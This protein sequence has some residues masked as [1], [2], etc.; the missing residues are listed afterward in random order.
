MTRLAARRLLLLAFRGVVLAVYGVAPILVFL[1]ARDAIAQ[2][3]AHSTPWEMQ[4]APRGQA[5]S[6]GGWKATASTF[7]PHP[8]AAHDAL[9][10]RMHLP[11]T[12]P[13]RPALLLRSE[14]RFRAQCGDEALTSIRAIEPDE[15]YFHGW[16][17][18]M[19]GVP[20]RC[21][22]GAVTFEVLD[23]DAV[24]GIAVKL[25]DASAME[26]TLV[27]R[28]VPHVAIAAIVVLL[29]LLVLGVGLIRKGGREFLGFGAFLISGGV[30]VFVRSRFPG[31]FFGSKPWA[32]DSVELLTLYAIP[33][34]YIVFHRATFGSGLRNSLRV[35][36]WVSGLYF[37]VAA[38]IALTG[39]IPLDRTLS[40][41]QCLLTLVLVAVLAD[42]IRL[43][44]KGNADARL[45]MG[46]L[47]AACLVFLVQ[48]LADLEALPESMVDVVRGLP[49]VPMGFFV[50]IVFLGAIV[51]RRTVDVYD[52]LQVYARDLERQN[53]ALAES[54]VALETQ[55]HELDKKNTELSRINTLKDEFLANTSH[56]LRTPLNG[57]IGL[58][59]S[60]FETTRSRL[61]ASERAHLR[62]I[63]MSGKR[64][65]TLINDILDFSKLRHKSIEL[66]RRA[67]D[68]H[69]AVDAIVELSRPL[70]GA[71]SVTLSNDVPQSIAKVA[72]DENRLQQ[73]L[74]NLVANAIKF[75]HA[76]SVRIAATLQGDSVRVTVRDTGIGIDASKL[77]RIFESFEQADG[78]TEREYGGT[79]LGLAITKKLVELHGGRLDVTSEVGIG[80]TFS[81]T[82]PRATDE[83]ASVPAPAFR[84]EPEDDDA[85]APLST[86]VS[87][88]P[89]PR[90]RYRV[91]AA[92]DDPVNLAVLGAQLK[93]EGFDIVQAADGFEALARL[94]GPTRF[95]AL[96]LD[97]M[98]PRMSGYEV[99]RRVRRI[100]ATKELPVLLLTAKNQPDDIVEGFDAGANDYLTKPFSRKELLARVQTHI[101]M[102]QK[103]TAFG[104]FVPRE[105][106]DLLGKRDVADVQRGDCVLRDMSVLFSDI[107]GF[108]TMSE[109]MAPDETFRFLNRCLERIGPR[110]RE[111]NGFI[112]KYIG[113]SVMALFPN[114][115]TDAVSAALAIA[116]EIE[117]YSASL[118]K[119]GGSAMAVGTAIH[120]GP[121]MLGT[122]GEEH[123][124]EATVIADTVN[125]ASR[126]EGIAKALSVSVLI[127]EDI[128]RAHAQP[129]ELGL[130]SLGRIRVRGR[131]R[132]MAVFEVT[133]ACTDDVRNA[134]V[135]TK[136]A[137]AEAL[138]VY[139]KADFRQSVKLCEALLTE[140]PSDGPARF[141]LTQS[142]E[143]ARSV[144]PDSWDGTLDVE[145]RVET[146]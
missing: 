138:A 140:T 39:A 12:L 129:S 130:R 141:L 123:R 144:I 85:G 54:K 48:V 45:F 109:Q 67:V 102:A 7:A 135:K 86:R 124:I 145:M 125:V 49:L 36:A 66:S 104:R 80:S 28:Y 89:V 68:V 73:I 25:G 33:P 27:H 34:L 4:W 143:M 21:V 122:I 92:D 1:A 142:R 78:S 31:F 59:E 146:R 18:Y 63:M 32:W 8:Q 71:R 99:C 29:G 100:A 98:M 75:T 16:A 44:A 46:G 23:E 119:L 5:P 69:G 118:V 105:F 61:V 74:H 35:V 13:D 126:L 77:D 137:F 112:D 14:G 30:Y 88:L 42:A 51:V 6:S 38:A 136:D 91:L 134:R 94:D 53:T 43:T 95:D 2:S 111:H 47:G 101:W 87:A 17:P 20:A 10:L 139:E 133:A 72:A 76:G 11:A 37:A 117:I 22:G 128:A 113:D 50:L 81:F 127:S 115:A 120:R 110:I 58:A 3:T 40:P 131:L 56:E 106:L 93:Q 97:V 121:L 116:R 41:F 84:P 60:V 9:W 55:S 90:R 108:T 15:G 62:M 114:D 70:V 65:A 103:N 52:L 96:L 24:A 19:L 64:L 107:R 132:P 26:T 83:A 57:I 79:G 82:L